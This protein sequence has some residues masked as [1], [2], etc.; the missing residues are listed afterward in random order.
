MSY[1]IKFETFFLNNTKDLEK[2]IF[3]HILDLNYIKLTTLLAFLN[4]YNKFELDLDN[5]FQVIPTSTG[6]KLISK[7]DIKLNYDQLVLKPIVQFLIDETYCDIYN[8]D[9]KYRLILTPKS[10]LMTL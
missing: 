4:N 9:N 5:G 7:K 1:I 8:K 6:P 3:I 2:Y 10:L